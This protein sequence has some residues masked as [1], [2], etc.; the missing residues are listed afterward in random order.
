MLNPPNNHTYNT[1]LI[2]ALVTREIKFGH[3]DSFCCINKPR[4]EPLGDFL[5]NLISCNP[6]K[7]FSQTTS[8]SYLTLIF[9]SSLT[10]LT[11]LL[12]QCSE[13]KKIVISVKKSMMHIGKSVGHYQIQIW[14]NRSVLM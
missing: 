6:L 10:F 1:L 7:D 8:F 11:L 14:L 12:C 5:G 3:V 2:L 13:M 9:M 4:L